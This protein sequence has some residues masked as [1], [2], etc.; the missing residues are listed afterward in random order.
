MVR[1]A[2]G[3]VQRCE[4]EKLAYELVV[5]DGSEQDRVESECDG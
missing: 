5:V 3:L 2:R 4:R 1:A